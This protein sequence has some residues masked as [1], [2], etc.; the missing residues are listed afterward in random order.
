MYSWSSPR[1]VLSFHQ[2]TQTYRSSIQYTTTMNFTIWEKHVTDRKHWAPLPAKHFWRHTTISAKQCVWV[3]EQR[4]WTW[5]W[6]QIC[7]SEVY[8]VWNFWLRL[9][10]CFGWMCS[11]TFQSFGLRLLSKLQSELSKLLAV[12]KRP[13]P[14]FALKSLK[15]RIKWISWSLQY[16]SCFSDKG[17]RWP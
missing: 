11:D 8:R 6:I 15:N 17:L 5:I 7:V 2:L 3:A 9:H 12:S 10:S 16:C 4:R 13:Y 14:V 1:N